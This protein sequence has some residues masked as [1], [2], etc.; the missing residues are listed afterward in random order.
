MADCK[1]LADMDMVVS[2][3]VAQEVKN[4]E[5]EVEFFL[6]PKWVGNIVLGFNSPT[7][8]DDDNCDVYIDGHSEVAR[9]LLEAGAKVNVRDILLVTP[10][11]LAALGKLLSSLELVSYQWVCGLWLR[12]ERQISQMHCSSP[13]V[14]D[15]VE[16]FVGIYMSSI[17]QQQLTENRIYRAYK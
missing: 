7:N 3:S 17:W 10:L 16:V 4:S 15:F 2:H 12:Q 13:G 11:H 5:L 6:K 9:L 14:V 1:S 8:V